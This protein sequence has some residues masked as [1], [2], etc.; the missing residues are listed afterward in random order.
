MSEPVIDTPAESMPPE[1]GRA[2]DVG[3]GTDALP[4]DG[5]AGVEVDGSGLRVG[6]NIGMTGLFLG[7][8]VLKE[9]EANLLAS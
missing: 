6:E 5:S 2:G 1:A 9:G 4:F 3:G 7:Q 8:V